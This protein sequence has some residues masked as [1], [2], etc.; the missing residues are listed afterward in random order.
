MRPDTEIGV[1]LV[2]KGPLRYRPL[3]PDSSDPAHPLDLLVLG[4]AN[5]DL[6]LLGDVEPAFGQAERLVERAHLTVGGSGAIAACGAAR[7]GLRVGFCG[8]V[9]DDLFGRFLRARLE[10]RWRGRRRV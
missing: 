5:P 6:V 10:G 2:R 3:V 8:V 4:D 7:L 1:G 9:G